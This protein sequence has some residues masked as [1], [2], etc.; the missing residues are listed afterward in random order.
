MDTVKKV[1]IVIILFGVGVVF[2]SWAVAENASKKMA[3][4][5]ELAPD[6]VVASF[7]QK[8]KKENKPLSDGFH[9]FKSDMTGDF[10]EYLSGFSGSFN[11]ITC[12]ASFPSYYSI[13]PPVIEGDNATVIWNGSGIEG[14]ANIGLKLVN[15]RWLIDSVSC[16][17]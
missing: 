3:E 2:G 10:K 13:S 7:Y 12:S 15:G 8:W 4:K 5:K 9:T 14:K 1:A 17:E 16:E 11:P 6:Q